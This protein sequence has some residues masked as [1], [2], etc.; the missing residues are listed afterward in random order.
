MAERMLVVSDLHLNVGL[1]AATLTWDR[2]ENFFADAAFSD[3]LAHYRGTGPAPG[4][5]DSPSEGGDGELAADSPDTLV[6][7]GDAFDFIRI[8]T[9]PHSEDEYRRWARALHALGEVERAERIERLAPL[10]PEERRRHPDAV[11]SSREER[12]GLK[13]DDYKTIW[14]L[15]E[16][17]TGH[18]PVFEALAGWIEDGGRLVFLKGN[19]DLELHWPLVRRALR[20]TLG[21]RAGLDRAV[22]RER[23]EFEEESLLSDNVYIEHGHRWE[24]MTAVHT[25]TPWLPQAPDQISL[26]LGSFVNRYL[27]NGIERLDP[28]VDNVKPVGNAFTALLRRHPLEMFR[29][30][31]RGWTFLRRALRVKGLFNSIGSAAQI[32]ALVLVPMTALVVGLAFL[33]GEVVPASR[34]A[35]L[36]DWLAAALDWLGRVPRWVLG[37]SIAGFS[38]PVL[39]PVLAPILREIGRFLGLTGK[40]HLLDGAGKV[41]RHVF[42]DGEAPDTDAHAVPSYVVMGHTHWQEVRRL[43]GHRM[44]MN[45]GTWVPIWPRD[46]QDLAGRVFYGFLEFTRPD[47][48]SRWRGRP[49]RWAA[50]AREPR[51]ARLMSPLE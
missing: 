27:I 38:L 7:A 47:P 26:P 42:P 50:G 40:D 2:R 22:A 39:F 35:V 25:E 4:V 12:F 43:D 46:R 20:Y 23:I 16:I 14:K 5:A 6:I 51:P 18:E 11:V 13:T 28:F 24:A 10:S 48:E 8:D 44:Y 32:V 33:I 45:S 29:L 37:L 19:H 9:C 30:Y 34:L 36:P 31:F 41:G 15:L 3:W 49:M 1:D 21:R 17:V